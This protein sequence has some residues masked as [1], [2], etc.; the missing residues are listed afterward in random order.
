MGANDVPFSVRQALRF[1]QDVVGYRHLADIVQGGTVTD[2]TALGL[3]Q[4]HAPREL[5]GQA[6]KSL[7]MPLHRGIARLDGVGQ[8]GNEAL[9]HRVEQAQPDHVVEAVPALS[10]PVDRLE[11]TLRAKRL[12][13]EADGPCRHR[14]GDDGDVVDCG[15]HH[16]GQ[17][18]VEVQRSA[19]HLAPVSLGQGVVDDHDLEVAGTAQCRD[20]TEA[21]R[22]FHHLVT[23]CLQAQPHHSTDQRVIVDDEDARHRPACL[24]SRTRGNGCSPARII[25]EKASDWQPR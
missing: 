14:L 19:D 13:Q 18:G 4:P 11:Q 12:G 6:G 21:V 24:R 23:G 16:T 8:N 5:V 25:A 22:R 20:G 2:R 9:Q 15:A 10:C 7:T 1:P 17:A 3:V